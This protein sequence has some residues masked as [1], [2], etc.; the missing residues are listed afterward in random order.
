MT[1][2]HKSITA[3]T[4]LS[5]IFAVIQASI[6][7]SYAGVTPTVPPVPVPPPLTG[8]L[9]I[10][11]NRPI[12]VNGANAGSGASILTGSTI[13]TPDQVGATITLGSLSNLE[14]GPNTKLSLDFDQDGNV[15]VTLVRGCATVRTKQNVLGEV[16]TSQ[17]VAGKTDRRKKGFLSVC[18]PPG[19]ATPTVLTA[20]AAGAAAAGGLSGLDLLAIIPVVVGISSLPLIFRGGNP[21][22]SGP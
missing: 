5:L 8:I 11:G 19:A 6:G 4:A 17:G 1:S 13:E 16:D 22:P 9:K 7:I 18:F 3:A 14:I 15:R 10:N 21:S 20:E 2:T 12:T